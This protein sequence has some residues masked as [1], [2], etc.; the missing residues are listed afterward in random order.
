MLSQLPSFL[1]L[2]NVP[3]FSWSPHSSLPCGVPS[4]TWNYSI[5]NFIYI[6]RQK[7]K[8]RKWLIKIKDQLEDKTF[9][10]MTLSGN[11]KQQGQGQQR[12]ETVGG[13]WWRASSC[14][15][16]ASINMDDNQMTNGSAIIVYTTH[17]GNIKPLF[18]LHVSRKHQCNRVL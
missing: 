17:T 4:K 1:L 18:S 11:R 12:Q 15:T 14:M 5:T 9:G 2:L 3:K 6:L 16:Q 7:H 13:F 10:E 8:I